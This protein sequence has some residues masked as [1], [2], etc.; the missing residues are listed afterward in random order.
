MGDGY[1]PVCTS[2]QNW[3]KRNKFPTYPTLVK[4]LKHYHKKYPYICQFVNFCGCV[5]TTKSDLD[6]HE[7]SC[8]YCKKCKKMFNSKVQWKNHFGICKKKRL[9]MSESAKNSKKIEVEDMH[10]D[11]IP[12]KITEI[13][14]ESEKSEKV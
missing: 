5:F 14:G 6:L 11:I 7:K 9:N 1:C 2:Q 4:H 12:S 10:C 3:D 13:D 8:F